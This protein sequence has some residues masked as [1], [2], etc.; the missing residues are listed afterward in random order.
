MP[1]RKTRA[2]IAQQTV[3]ILTFGEYQTP[4]GVVVRIADQLE[5]AVRDTILYTPASLDRLISTIQFSNTRYSQNTTFQVVNATTFETARHFALEQNILHPLCLNFASAKNA[6]GGFL[7]GSQAQ[8]ESL[9]RASGLYAC[10]NP[11]R[12]YYD[13]NRNC[14]TCLYTHHMIYSPKVPVFRNDDDDLLP[15]PYLTSIITAPAVNAGAIRR[16]ETKKLD[17]IEATML[18]RIE[19]VLAVAVTHGH[20]AMILGAWGCGVFRND[21]ANIAKWFHHFLVEDDRFRN[22]F[23]TVIFAVLDHSDALGTISP[24]VNQFATS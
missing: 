14:G 7:N 11:V 6:G 13:S 10:I 15:E 5:A 21:P 3:E 22:V 18:E 4:N 16:N 20:D 2:L 9:A 23:R 19:R 12:G 24:F 8:E 1:S 17:Q